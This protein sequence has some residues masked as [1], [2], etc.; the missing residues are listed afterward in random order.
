MATR[1]TE[2]DPLRPESPAAACVPEPTVRLS[3]E[4]LEH[5]NSSKRLISQSFYENSND[6]AISLISRMDRLS[7]SPIPAMDHNPGSPITALN[8]NEDMMYYYEGLRGL[9]KLL[10]R[11]GQD[12]FVRKWEDGYTMRKCI[13][14]IGLHPLVGKM[15]NGIWDAILNILCDTDW[16]HIDIVRIGYSSRAD[17]NTPVV[18]ISVTPN[19]ISTEDAEAIVIQCQQFLFRYGYSLIIVS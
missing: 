14:N 15:E 18:L 16:L 2:K 4:E 5:H 8:G 3:F 13:S 19:T 11:T 17:K 6:S 1:A 10:A 7:T 12:T 9:P